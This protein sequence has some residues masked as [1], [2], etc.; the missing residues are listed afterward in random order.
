VI[1]HFLDNAGHKKVPKMFRD[2][3]REYKWCRH[4][5]QPSLMGGKVGDK[6]SIVNKETNSEFLS[7]TK[8]K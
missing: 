8:F 6:M 3:A 2:V 7:S 5:W 4:H 1:F